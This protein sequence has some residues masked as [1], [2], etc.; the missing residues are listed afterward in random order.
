[1]DVAAGILAEA[2]GVTGQRD[3]TKQGFVVRELRAGSPI[4]GSLR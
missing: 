2:A 3:W 4:S 1:M